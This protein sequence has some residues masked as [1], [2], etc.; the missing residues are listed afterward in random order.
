MLA[1][2]F[3]AFQKRHI[4]LDCFVF[5]ELEV[6]DKLASKDVGHVTDSFFFIFEHIPTKPNQFDFDS[7]FT[8][9]F[10]HVAQHEST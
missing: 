7:T 1:H 4:N 5:G 2:I 6:I 3:L 8:E 9:L 10:F